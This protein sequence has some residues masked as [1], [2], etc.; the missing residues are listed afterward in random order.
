VVIIGDAL[1][2]DLR[3]RAQGML[4]HTCTI[5]RPGAPT[6]DAAGGETVTYTSVASGVAC[7]LR[8]A[9]IQSEERAVAGGIAAVASWIVR[10]PAGTDVRAADRLVTTVAGQVKTLEVL[11]PVGGPSYELLRTV[12]CTEIT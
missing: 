2:A 1:L 4:G 6:Y 8:P 7:M 10:V 9:G 5:S 12:G 3:T 11:P